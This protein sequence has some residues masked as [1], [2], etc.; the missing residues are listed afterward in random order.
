MPRLRMAR[1]ALRIVRCRRSTH[2][3]VRVMARYTGKCS[4]AV[5][6]TGSA[7][8]I[9]RFMADIPGIAPVRIVVQIAGVTVARTTKNVDLNSR[10]VLGILNGRSAG[11]LGVRAPGPMTRFAMNARLAGLYPRTGSHR[12]GAGRVTP[13]AEQRRG[14]RIECAVDT[15]R[16][17]SMARRRSER[18]GSGEITQAVFNDGVVTGL[19]DPGGCLNAGAECPLRMTAGAGIRCPRASERMGVRRLRL[20]LKLRRV[21]AAASR[22]CNIARIDILPG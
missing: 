11:R 4:I 22:A 6:E 1:A 9:R 16:G 14:H 7:V 5:A 10:Q 17:S 2:G 19:A 20:R 18:L 21:A 12:E 8:Q 13:E 15:I 3:L